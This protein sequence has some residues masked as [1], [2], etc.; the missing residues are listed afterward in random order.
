MSDLAE[1]R[2]QLRELRKDHVKPVSRM[3]KSDIATEI[4][5]LREKR[6][7]TAPV[8][9][10]RGAGVKKSEAAVESIKKA[11]ASEFPVKPSKKEATASKAEAP[12][13]KGEKT[14][15]AKMS[16]AQMMAMLQE[17]SSDEE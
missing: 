5:R 9:S 16:K 13:A 4:E 17:M 7:T 14:P 6:E 11:K 10:V 8:A 2:K 15:K 1:M 12:K 3:K